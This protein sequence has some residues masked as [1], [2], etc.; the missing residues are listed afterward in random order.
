MLE[1][2]C[3]AWQPSA[4]DILAVIVILGFAIVSAKRGFVECFFGFISTIVAVLVAFFLMKS[5]VEWTNG[6]FGLQKVLQN[7]CITALGKINGFNVD[8]SNEGLAA[9]LEEKNL[10]AFLAK[11]VVE[12][13]GDADIPVGTTLAQVVGAPLGN[14]ATSLIAWLAVF[15]LAKL[16]LSILKRIFSSIVRNIPLVGGVNTLLGFAV[17]ALQGLLILSGVLAVL[18]MLPIENVITFFNECAFVGWLYNHNP[19]NV[20]LGWIIV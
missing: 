17:G 13:V 8:V 3:A 1:N 12:S 9:L 19:I 2:L 18:A 14:F 5:V 6:L 15:L 16:L 11:F 20:I 7:G 4:V 10:P